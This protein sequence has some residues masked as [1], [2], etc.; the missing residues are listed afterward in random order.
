EKKDADFS[1]YHQLFAKAIQSP[2]KSLFQKLMDLVPK[3]S[4]SSLDLRTIQVPFYIDS[5]PKGARILVENQY[6]ENCPQIIKIGW[7]EQK[8]IRLVYQNLQSQEVLLTREG[9]ILPNG[10]I[11]GSKPSSWLV[12]PLS[13]PA[14]FLQIPGGAFY[15]HVSPSLETVLLFG[16]GLHVLSRD[17]FQFVM[18]S[19]LPFHTFFPIP[20]W[21]NDKIW[22][23]W[24]RG[25]LC[26]HKKNGR[27][28]QDFQQNLP[29]PLGKV[30]ALISKNQILC[31]SKQTL[32]IYN[33]EK[34]KKEAFFSLPYPII[35][36]LVPY[37]KEFYYLTA[38]GV[39]SLRQNGTNW[40]IKLAFPLLKNP[41]GSLVY[42]NGYFYWPA[43]DRIQGVRLGV[44]GVQEIYRG[45]ERIY[46]FH[47]WK[48]NKF[49]LLYPKKIQL[50]EL[51]GTQAKVVWQKKMKSSFIP[52]I[53]W[54]QKHLYLATRDGRLWGF[55][56]ERKI[57]AQGF[58]LKGKLAWVK[59]FDHP[60]IQWFCGKEYLWVLTG[61]KIYR[62]TL[63][64]K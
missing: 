36:N 6:Y 51:Y 8:R 50:L 30:L 45:E 42:F 1:A 46:S 22:I 7:N 5:L 15:A 20:V 12:L 34:N 35:G 2:S 55:R 48:E 9:A 64:K 29:S 47:H 28:V 56:M 10:K 11:F 27:W 41:T 44:S 18:N 13:P 24:D 17:P 32:V 40:Q 16:E 23:S 53:S 39:Y 52:W 59:S 33:L 60:P 4:K 21:K 31:H 43:E 14:K 3:I 25:L 57:H 54:D 58:Q 63:E 19:F 62:V 37:K 49:L 38:K 61:T 26:L